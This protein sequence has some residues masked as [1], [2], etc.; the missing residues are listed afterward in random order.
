M[1]R[2]RLALILLVCC[3]G[4]Y[5]QRIQAPAATLR[6]VAH[7][8]SAHVYAN[9][10]FIGTARVLAVRPR[11]LQAGRYRITIQAPGYFPHDV[12]VEL[13]SGRTTIEIRLREVPP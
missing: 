5:I 2:L 12:E 13:Q 8:P 3:W 9:E 6:V 1:V 7:P 4:C 10:R 11:E